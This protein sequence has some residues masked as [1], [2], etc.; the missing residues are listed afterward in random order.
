M[1]RNSQPAAKVFTF[2][3]P[4]APPA[5][6]VLSCARDLSF[7]AT[8]CLRF[9]ASGSTASPQRVW[10]GRCLSPRTWYGSHAGDL[11]RRY[12]LVDPAKLYGWLKGLLNEAPGT[13]LRTSVLALAGIQPKHV[14]HL[15]HRDPLCWHRPSDGKSQRNGRYADRDAL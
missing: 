4:I 11:V 9:L 8:H 7:S 6:A 10:G 15:A 13:V 5:Q 3:L 12:E 2:E 14:A 1:L